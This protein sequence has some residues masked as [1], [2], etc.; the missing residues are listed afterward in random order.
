MFENNNLKLKMELSAPRGYVFIEK[1]QQN[2]V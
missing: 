1:H 2:E